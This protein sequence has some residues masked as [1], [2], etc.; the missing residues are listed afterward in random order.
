MSTKPLVLGFI[1][2]LFFQAKVEGVVHALGGTCVILSQEE[3]FLAALEEE[4]P[5]AIVLEAQAAKGEA[6]GLL[7]KLKKNPAT[8]GFPVMAFAPHTAEGFLEE[9]RRKGAD[10]VWT[11]GELHRNLAA[12]LKRLQG[13][14]H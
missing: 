11:N 3:P 14:K 10:E 13:G 5:L 4:N 9:A 7:E 1:E 6:L 8:R 2:N 12:W